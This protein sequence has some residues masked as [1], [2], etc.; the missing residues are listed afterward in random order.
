MLDGKV[1]Q[2][3]KNRGYALQAR[4]DLDK[5]IADYTQAIALDPKDAEL[6][7]LAP[8]PSI[9]NPT[10]AVRLLTTRRRSRSTRKTPTTT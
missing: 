6:T 4:G 10:T 7:P 9:Q 3:Y 1:V 5:A 8:Q 2:Y